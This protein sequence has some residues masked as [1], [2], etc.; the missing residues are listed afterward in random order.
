[1]IKFKQIAHLV[2]QFDREQKDVDIVSSILVSLKNVI[3]SMQE[4]QLEAFGKLE[5]ILEVIVKE[6]ESQ[7]DSIFAKKTRKQGIN[8]Y[9]YQDMIKQ[10]I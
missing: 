9:K 5:K 1:M 4:E 10:E 7:L 6:P 3:N 8:E 2:R